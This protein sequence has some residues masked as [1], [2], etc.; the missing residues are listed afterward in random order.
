MLEIRTLG[1]F[2]LGL[3][4]QPVQDMGSRKAEALLVYLAVEVGLHNRNVLAA[5]LWPE[6][7]QVQAA[8]SLRVALT[9][10]RRRLDDY[11]EISRETVRIKPGARIYLDL[12]DLQ[13]NLASGQTER[14]MEIYQG[15]FLQGFHLHDAADFEEWVRWEA[16][17]A[18]SPFLKALHAAAD[19][20]VDDGNFAAGVN[21]LQR[22]LEL[23]PLDERAHERCMLLLA[24]DGQR[25]AALAQY[26][27]CCA[28]FAA[29]LGAEPAEEI[30]RLH[31]KILRGEKLTPPE[32]AIPGHNLPAAQT[33][34][35]GRD[36][37]LEQIGR[38]LKDP[39][40]RLITLVGPGGC[41]KTRLA[42]Q[43][44]GKARRSFA[45]GEYFV[46]LEACHA[47]NYLISAI[48]KVLQFSIDGYA[49]DFDPKTQLLDFLRNRSTLLVMDSF[50]HLV[51]GAGLLTEILE[52]APK[53]KLIVTS[54]QRL[55]L[56]GEWVIQLDGLPVH[57]AGEHNEP[58]PSDAVQLF[59]M[60]ARQAKADF[61][62]A[63]ADQEPVSR[64]CQMVEGMPLGIELAAA[65]HPMLTP[66]EIAAEMEKGLDFL[67]TSKRDV[68]EKHRSL[69]AVF[70]STWALLDDDQKALFSQ[71]AIFR[72]GFTRQAAEQVCGASLAQLSALRD[73]SLLWITGMGS[74]NMH[75]LLRQYALEKMNQAEEEDREALYSRFS[76]YY[77][78]RLFERGMDFWGTRMIQA[79]DET[80]S[81]I[82]NLRA[83][84]DWACQH[85]EEGET[86]RALI[87]LMYFYVCHGWHEGKDVFRDIARLRSQA[88]GARGVPDLAN[89]PVV[90]ASR[91]HQA[92]F[93]TELGQIEESE[94]I[95]RECMKGLIE[96]GMKEELTECLNNL[97]VNASFRGEYEE[98][99]EW[100]EKAVLVGRECGHLVWYT[101]LLWLGHTYFLLG[102]Y[103]QGI[104]T[105]KKSLELFER[106]GTHW[107]IGFGLSK[108]GL[109]LDGMGKHAQALQAHRDA[110]AIFNRINNSAGQGFALSR[111]CMSAGLLGEYQLAVEYGLE[112]CQFCEKIGHQ[113]VICLTHCRLIFAYLGLG[114]IQKAKQSV[115]IALEQSGREQMLPILLYALAGAASIFAALDEEQAAC[116]LF[117]YVRQ[118]PQTPGAFLMQAERWMEGLEEGLLQREDIERLESIEIGEI[119]D[120]VKKRLA[121]LE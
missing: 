40:C 61:Q 27:R 23:D 50:E 95:S 41:G 13:E 20:A 34:F 68:P 51:D 63:E 7:A 49:S 83:A 54:R 120:R 9:I 45:D 70:D 107:G 100:L 109:A 108:M 101:C 32:P 99:C 57:L 29:E 102:E 25:G 1:G 77:I 4:G 19:S 21:Y 88:L 105:L 115:I 6:C 55:D 18:R 84:I 3:N 92:L 78:H 121:A 69:R 15:D 106:L 81:E 43:A 85:W 65:W 44:A 11:L 76:I 5:L 58:R 104:L 59:C 64:I 16:D 22:L 117:S 91:V 74:Y 42:L 47:T 96:L 35:V 113:W 111:M 72:G 62:L 73:K 116:E 8:T 82:E 26:Q 80:R 67:A 28:V 12:A 60:R 119:I 87:S 97:G 10:L 39:F 30:Q 53:V 48:A 90:L 89:D 24:L 118:H 31:G 36:K 110:L 79:R 52:A 94:A 103:E 33:C 2:S 17:R 93:L 75:S 114:E 46:P 38:L 112:A 71:L 14:A 66:P 56:H 86:R 98:S 37:E